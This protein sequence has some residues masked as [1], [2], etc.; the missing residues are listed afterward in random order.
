MKK[1]ATKAA[2]AQPAAEESTVTL[3]EGMEVRFVGYADE[4]PD[5]ERLL[6][7]GEVYKVSGISE[8]DPSQDY[9]GGEPFVDIE[10]PGFDKKKKESDENPKVLSVILVEGEYEVVAEE[11]APAPVKTAAKAAVKTAAKT[12]AKAAAAPAKTAAKAPTK[13][14]APAKAAT[15]AKAPAKAEETTEE[16]DEDQLPELTDED[17]EVLALINSGRD[18]IELAQELETTAAQSEYRLGGVLFHIKKDGA[19]KELDDGAYAEK[20]GFDLFVAAYFNIGYRKA[21][22]LIDIY[23]GFTQAKIEDPASRVAAMGW[24]KAA[25]I[26]RPMLEEGAN[27]TEL[28]ELA[29]QSTVEDLSTTLREMR[30]VGAKAVGG[31]KVSRTTFKFRLLEQDG[32]TVASVLEAV[33]VTQNLKDVGEALVHVVNDWAAANAPASLPRKAPVQSAPA[34]RGAAK[35]TT[36]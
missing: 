35:K 24:A 32:A 28:V 23:V 9:E 18:P 31:T 12:P 11:P 7:A 6:V 3:Q 36:A 5:E 16:T 1:S 34:K 17:P 14:A 30:T 29:D 25:K 27:A 4:V 19:Y 20:K 10:N 2:P 33:K 26:A 15:K 8:A 21:M 13:A 22:N